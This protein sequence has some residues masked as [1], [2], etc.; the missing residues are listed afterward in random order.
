MVRS[1]L[2]PGVH[3]FVTSGGKEQGASILQEKISLICEM[4]PSFKK[5]IDWGRGKTLIGK[6]K[7]KYVFTNGSVLDNLAASE[8]TRGQRRHGGVMEECVG[9]DDNILREVIIP[10][11]AIPRRAQDGTMH[12]EEPVNKSQVYITTAGY[13]GTYP[14]DRLIGFLVRMVTQPDRCFVMGGT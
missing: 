10:V 1:I 11:M 2:Y 8:K 9:I 3:L 12:E 6:D 5:E 7:V 14:Y 13:K 4:I